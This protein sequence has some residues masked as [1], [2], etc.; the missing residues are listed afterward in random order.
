MQRLYHVLILCR[1][2]TEFSGPEVIWDGLKVNQDESTFQLVFGKN[3]ILRAKD[4][5]DHP[6][7]YQWKVQKPASVMVWGCISAQGMGD[8]HI[9]EGTIDGHITLELDMEYHKDSC[10]YPCSSPYICYLLATSS[11]IMALTSTAM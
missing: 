11:V 1:N 10:L 9:C 8:L 4:E 6:D 2:T 5:K 7:S 3:R